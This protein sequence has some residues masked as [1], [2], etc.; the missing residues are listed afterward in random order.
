MN[1]SPEQERLNQQ[2]EALRDNREELVDALDHIE[3][4]CHGSRT[5]TRR[6]RWIALR[7][8]CA[9]DGR[10]DAWKEADVPVNDP[11]VETLRA[12][13]EQIFP[14]C[15]RELAGLIESYNELRGEGTEEELIVSITE[16]SV[17]DDCRM[18]VDWLAEVRRNV[19]KINNEERRA[20]HVEHG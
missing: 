9:I 1:A 5:Q 12:L 4:T 14:Y 17:R 7:A 11:L 3:R 20:A 15:K 18:L 19:P 13:L 6:I 10:G 8:R 2:L 16:V